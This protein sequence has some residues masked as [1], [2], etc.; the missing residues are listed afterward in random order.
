MNQQKVTKAIVLAAV[1]AVLVAAVTGRQ[2]FADGGRVYLPLVLVRWPPATE[3]E[4]NVIALPRD[5][6]NYGAIIEGF[7]RTYGVKVNELNPNAGSADELQAIRDHKDGG[8]LAPDVIDLGPAFGAL[9][10]AEGL[11]QP[12]K[13]NTWATIPSDAKDEEGYWYGDYFGVIAFMINKEVVPNSPFSWADLRK[14]EY[15]GR[16]ALSGDPR[17][18]NVAIQTV[19]AASLA[20]GGTVENPMPGLEIFRDLYASGNL[21]TLIATNARLASGETP[22]RI[23]WD[24][25]ALAGADSMGGNP[26]IA[27]IAPQDG[28]LAGWYVQA[29]SAYAPHPK[30]AKLWME[31]LYS[32]E[33]QLAWM[34]GYCHPVREADL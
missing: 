13:V 3:G 16:V 5:W 22:V 26:P 2:S 24:Y 29:I 33:G 21:N 1:A 10:K 27:I 32:D 15:Y 23:T 31:Y 25:N 30:A 19:Q 34:R 20:N 17:I 8:P 11:I 18:S 12:Y 9:A 28:L 6:C 14:P 7:S 4:L